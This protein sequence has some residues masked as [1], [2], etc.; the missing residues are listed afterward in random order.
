MGIK[1][2]H[3]AKK[4]VPGMPLRIV[5]GKGGKHEGNMRGNIEERTRHAAKDCE[6]KGRE[7]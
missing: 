4:S 5:R 2:K 6:G 7:T 1:I 3:F